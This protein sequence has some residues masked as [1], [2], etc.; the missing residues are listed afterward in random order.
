MSK[1]MEAGASVV[2]LDVSLARL[3]GADLQRALQDMCKTL[4]F[5]LR[6]WVAV[7]GAYAGDGSM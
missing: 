5:I 3:T 1:D 4:G 2:L 7:E 6:K